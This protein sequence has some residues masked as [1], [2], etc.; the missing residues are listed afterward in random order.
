MSPLLAVEEVELE[1]AV[2]VVVMLVLATEG[3]VTAWP[4]IGVV[5]G[6]VKEAVETEVDP[7]AVRWT[8]VATVAAEEGWELG[9]WGLSL[10]ACR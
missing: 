3:M 9:E 5:T 6:V 2:V 8:G 1:L 10:W 7:P 4:E